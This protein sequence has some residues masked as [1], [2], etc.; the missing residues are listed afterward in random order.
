MEQPLPMPTPE[1][2]SGHAGNT[3]PA[4]DMANAIRAGRD[5]DAGHTSSDSG[6]KRVSN[7]QMMYNTE[8]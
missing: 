3:G 8:M 4:T 6:R 7:I 5:P 1:D 2:W